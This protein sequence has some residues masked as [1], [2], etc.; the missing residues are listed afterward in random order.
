VNF[1]FQSTNILQA[2]VH[3]SGKFSDRKENRMN[4]PGKY[5]VNGRHSK[6][7]DSFNK[8]YR[9]RKY[10]QDRTYFLVHACANFAS[11]NP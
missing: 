3:P 5:G 4:K 10:A 11:F 1:F 6:A 9:I 8:Y 2:A 7:G